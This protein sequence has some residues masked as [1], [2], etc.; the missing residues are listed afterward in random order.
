M[1]RTGHS[2]NGRSLKNNAYFNSRMSSSEG[3]Q[4]PEER[5]D[6]AQ[7]HD[8]RPFTLV[9]KTI[10]KTVNVSYPNLLQKIVVFVLPGYCTGNCFN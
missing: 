7:V 3:E 6:G 9:H 8:N 1:N 5:K 4:L 2:T 10:K